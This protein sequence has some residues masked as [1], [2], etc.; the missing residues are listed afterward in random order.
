MVNVME[1]HGKNLMSWKIL[2]QSI[3]AQIIMSVN[4]CGVKCETS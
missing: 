4:K 3:I 1:N 2:I